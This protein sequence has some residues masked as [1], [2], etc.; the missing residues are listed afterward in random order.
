[1]FVGLLILLCS[2]LEMHDMMRNITGYGKGPFISIHNGFQTFENWRTFLPGSDR[3]ALGECPSSDYYPECNQYSV[4]GHPYFCF[5]RLQ[6]AP[7][8]QQVNRP[9]TEWGRDYNNTMDTYGF[10]AAGEWSLAFTDCA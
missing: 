1:V 4:D 7:L 2:Y 6:N 5:A 3:I 9:C 10:V 8:A